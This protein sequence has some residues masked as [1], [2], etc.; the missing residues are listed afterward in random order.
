METLTAEP[1][2]KSTK[3]F[4]DTI[5]VKPEGP[6]KVLNLP[7]VYTDTAKGRTI[8]ISTDGRY[9]SIPTGDYTKA[10]RSA[11]HAIARTYEIETIKF[12]HSTTQKTGVMQYSYKIATDVY[13]EII[14]ESLIGEKDIMGDQAYGIFF[15]D[16]VFCNVNGLK[17]GGKLSVTYVNK[18]KKIQTSDNK[19]MLEVANHL[20]DMY[21][22]QPKKLYDVASILGQSVT[23]KTPED[24][25]TLLGDMKSGIIY[26]TT[27]MAKFIETFIDNANPD[28][29]VIID[30]TK[31]KELGMIRSGKNGVQDTFTFNN[32]VIG[33]NDKTM[34][35]TM[36]NE[37]ETYNA[38]KLALEV[39]ASEN[40]K[41]EEGLVSE[42][43]QEQGTERRE[44]MRGELN[45][46]RKTAKNPDGKDLGI[47]KK[48]MWQ[49]KDDELEK[50]YDK[51]IL[52]K[53]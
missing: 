2:K 5:I 16:A 47:G 22:N 52:G 13:G 18:G 19:R 46:I 8:F 51:F 11:D 6:F 42:N 49:V 9:N 26:S 32:R 53:E 35:Y 12:D 34:L 30:I 7:L 31:G 3:T 36:K 1:K 50:L 23:G 45:A 38:L 21:E 37:P 24:V 43:A 17:K 4:T 10:A 14:R 48:Q 28:A 15:T 25:Y 44:K 33:Q 27:N 41:P 29:Q 40:E 39:K 20:R